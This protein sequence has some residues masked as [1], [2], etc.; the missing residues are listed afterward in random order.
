MFQMPSKRT[1]VPKS[2]VKTNLMESRMRG[3]PH[4]R[5]GKRVGRNRLGQ[6]LYGA[7]DSTSRNLK[8]SEADLALTRKLWQGGKLL[9][10][11]VID[12]LIVTPHT[13]CSLADDGLMPG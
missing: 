5:F 1:R 6:P 8:P 3:N 4:V 9:E 10:I 13:Y 11:S 12:H 2:R 7:P